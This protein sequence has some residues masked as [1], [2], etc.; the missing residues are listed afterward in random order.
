MVDRPVRK[1]RPAVYKLAGYRPKDTRVIGTDAVVAH[2]EVTI[3][4]NAHGAVIAHVFV[5]RRDVRFIDGAPVDINDA[6]ANLDIFAWQTDDPLDERLRM[7][8]RIPEDDNIAALN[9]LEAVD[10]FV[11]ENALLIRE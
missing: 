10:K 5:L 9:G 4:G 8:E 1:N 6:L 2:D 3:L 7:V 11:D